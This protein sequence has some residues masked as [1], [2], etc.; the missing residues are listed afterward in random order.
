MSMIK[1]AVNGGGY[2][3]PLSDVDE[4]TSEGIV[5]LMRI[6]YSLGMDVLGNYILLNCVT[7][8]I[9]LEDSVEVICKRFGVGTSLVMRIM[10]KKYFESAIIQRVVDNILKSNQNIVLSLI[11]SGKIFVLRERVL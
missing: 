8:E 10:Y 11:E 6:G 2:Q 1:Y 5:G 3:I 7:K 9:E 4:D